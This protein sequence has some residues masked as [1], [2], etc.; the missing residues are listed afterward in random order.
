MQDAIHR[1]LFEELDIRGAYVSLNKTWQAIQSGPR[2]APEVRDVLGQLCAVTAII[3]GNLKQAGRLTFQLSGQG[4]LPLL[5]IDCSADLNLRG[6]AK[7]EGEIIIGSSMRE[8]LGDGRLLMSL[9]VE[10]NKQPYQSYV[11]IEG[12][13]V[14]EIFEHYLSQ[15]EQLPTLLFMAANGQAAGALFLQKLPEADIKDADGWARISQLAATVKNEE[16]LGLD[17][18]TLLLR[19]FS[20][21][22][23]RLYPARE[24]RHDFP[25]DWEKIRTMLRSLGEEEVEKLISEHGEVLVSDDLSN[26]HYRFS[27]AEARALFGEDKPTLH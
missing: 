2:Y 8:M 11:P 27:P 6:F 18:E 26:H 21:E 22:D 12:D 3:A 16:L 10:G 19:L 17:V 4:P 7:Q 25:M 1:F 5:V 13:K 15:S 23:I 24:L 20:Q 9:D 14:A